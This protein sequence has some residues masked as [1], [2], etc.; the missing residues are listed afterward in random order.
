MHTA[1]TNTAPYVKFDWYVNFKPTK[2]VFSVYLTE[3]KESKDIKS[4]G[5]ALITQRN[6]ALATS[7]DDNPVT[8][9]DFDG[10]WEKLYFRESIKNGKTVSKDLTYSETKDEAHK[11]FASN[12]FRLASA[13][14]LVTEKGAVL[15]VVLTGTTRSKVNEQIEAFENIDFITL[16]AGAET[17]TVGS[18]SR[19]QEVYE[20]TVTETTK[21]YK[22]EAIDKI[23]GTVNTLKNI[24]EY[25]K[26][27]KTTSVEEDT[28]ISTADAEAAFADAPTKE[29]ADDLPI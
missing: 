29:D 10:F 17:V 5:W 27:G 6:V 9:Q 11:L 23:N 1:S 20:L 13:I 7:H 22:R 14:Y 28:S 15:K 26:T 25:K 12:S 18:G 3:S 21:E 2:W 19:S 8:S 4:I 16:E 24:L